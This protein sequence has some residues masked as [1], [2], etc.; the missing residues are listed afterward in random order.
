M[1][2]IVLLYKHVFST[3][4]SVECYCVPLL[5]NAVRDSS[6]AL[7]LSASSKTVTFYNKDTRGE[8]QRASFNEPQV[9]RVFHGSFHKVNTL[10]DSLREEHTQR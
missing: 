9:Q 2:P 5:R 10:H 3:V 1:I 4:L 8:I 7:L 6:N